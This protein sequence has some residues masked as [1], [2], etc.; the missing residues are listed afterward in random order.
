MYKLGELAQL[1]DAEL[2]GDSN[3]KIQKVATLAKAREGDISFLSNSKYK[4]LMATTKASAVIV[5]EVDRGLLSKNG[6]VARDPYVTY[7]KVATLLYPEV[8]PEAGIHS[9]C[10]L[11]KTSN[12]DKSASIGPN[13]VIGKEVKIGSGCVIGPG[14]IIEDNVEIGNDCRIIANVTLCH[15]VKLGARV[16]VHPG[17]VIGSDGFGLANDAGRWVKIPQVGSVI[18]GNDVEIGANSTID[19]GAIDD[20]VLEDGVKLDNL[21]QIAHNVKI[22]KNTAMAAGSAV[23]GSV[24]IGANCQIGGKVGIVGHLEIAD[25]VHVTAMSLVTH[26]IKDAGAYSSG[27][28]LQPNKEWH[29]N[30]VRNKQLD[31]LFHRV[32]DLEKQ[33]NQ[34]K[35]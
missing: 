17:V 12:V 16:T 35:K 26:S 10:M 20:T 9:S 34:Q 7:A 33:I 2:V 22:G 19:R 27:T 13:C 3:C 30:A 23:A 28:P 14:C 32:K 31:K 6:M 21:I 15:H 25:N 4:S 8:K 24:T 11:D 18:I 5:A 1:V 29:R